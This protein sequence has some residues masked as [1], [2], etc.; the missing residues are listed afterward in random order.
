MKDAHNVLMV[1]FRIDEV[2][3]ILL[4]YFKLAMVNLH[5]AFGVSSMCLSSAVP[6]L[7]ISE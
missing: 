5:A 7:F 2:Q 3:N 6:C 4:Q 1:T